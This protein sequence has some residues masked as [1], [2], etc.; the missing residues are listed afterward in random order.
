MI[1]DLVKTITDWQDDACEW[2][3]NPVILHNDQPVQ[4]CQFIGDHSDPVTSAPDQPKFLPHNSRYQF[5]RKLFHG[6]DS[7][8]ILFQ[9]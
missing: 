9:L 8:G 2:Q 4:I 3:S 7:K 6:P 5:D 1:P